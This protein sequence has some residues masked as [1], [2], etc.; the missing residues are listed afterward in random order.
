MLSLPDSCHRVLRQEVE[1]AYPE[2]GCGVLIGRRA[3]LNESVVRVMPC[4]NAD[5][6]PRR[7]FAISPED[8]ITAQRHA[9]SDGLQIIGFFH[10]HPD[11]SAEPSDTDLRKAHW[12]GCV[13]L[14]CAVHQGKMTEI[15]ATRLLEPR[16][17]VT[18]P[19]RRAAADVTVAPD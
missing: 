2:E 6:E 1:R 4:V 7:H 12:T 19:I 13:Y 3:D 9:R 10:S 16:Q 8:L 17:W 18:E 14:I 5:P 15:G 11:R